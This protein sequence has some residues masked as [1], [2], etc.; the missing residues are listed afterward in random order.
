MRKLKGKDAKLFEEF[1]NK[2]DT[3]AL[4]GEV[5]EA[6]LTGTWPGWEWIIEE[7]KKRGMWNYGQ[8][9]PVNG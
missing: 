8:S 5:A 4:D 7:R 6:M 2:V 9:D 3:E 1:I